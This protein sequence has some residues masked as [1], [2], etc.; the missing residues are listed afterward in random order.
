MKRILMPVVAGLLLA[1]VA[2]QAAVAAPGGG[3]GGSTTTTFT[4]S[5]TQLT[6]VTPVGWGGVEYV[7]V[8][9][10]TKPVA[11]GQATSSLFRFL[12][13]GG[14]TCWTSFGAVGQK[15]PANTSCTIAVSFY[16]NEVGTFTG[17]LSV[18]ECT[19][20][21]VSA[22]GG[23]VCDK[24]GTPQT[25]G[26]SGTAIVGVPDLTVLGV[27]LDTVGPNGPADYRVDVTNTQIAVV[28]PGVQVEGWWSTDE[29]LSEDDLPAGSGVTTGSIGPVTSVTPVWINA[30]SQP[31]AEQLYLIID[32]DP[33]HVV[34][35]TDDTNNT[36]A[37][38]L[39]AQ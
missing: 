17:T 12:D 4:L 38:L 15:I 32:L 28:Q 8:T 16:A 24:A 6:Y 27:V 39:S 36:R 18:A 3:S 31:S 10:K 2:A 13:T 22:S 37:V 29:V 7:T 19:R 33:Y 25:V 34:E 14:G 11:M 9:T 21:H 23:I 20:W 35:E 1:F 30:P 26:L 5:P